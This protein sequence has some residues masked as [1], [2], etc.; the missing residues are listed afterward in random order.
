[1][2]TSRAIKNNKSVIL[3][4]Q[5]SHLIAVNQ[6]KALWN[7]K[8]CQLIRAVLQYNKLDWLDMQEVAVVVLCQIFWPA[9]LLL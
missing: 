9:D 6:Y 4:Q 5:I 2:G 3:S 8:T 7:C 1:M